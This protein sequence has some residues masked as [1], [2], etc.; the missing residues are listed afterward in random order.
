MTS[1]SER[2][3]RQGFEG[4]APRTPDEFA[5]RW[6]TSDARQKLLAELD[7]Y[8]KQHPLNARLGEY[9]RSRRVEQAPSQR[10]KSPYIIS[11]HQQV[12]LTFWRAWRRLL[13]DPWFTIA[14]LLFNLVMAIMLGTVFLDLKQDTSS[15]YYRGGVI[16]F[17]LLFNAF[18]SMLE[19]SYL[20][21]S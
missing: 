8:E 18:A 3:V 2:I 10:P 12:G 14:Q 5:E 21:C 17:S 20:L 4:K 15:F 7:A 19:V 16:F 1:A 6:R 11:Y 13:A 9:R